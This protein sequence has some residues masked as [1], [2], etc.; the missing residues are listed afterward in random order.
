M[1]TTDRNWK[2]FC[3]A[4]FYWIGMIM[5]LACFAIVFAGN[6]DLIY[7]LQHSGF[8][9]S[10]TLAVIAM[11][12]FLAAEFCHT[13]LPSSEDEESSELAPE[14]GVIEA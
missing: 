11:L 5:A 10:W 12:S 6:T 13:D 8:P 7:R 2:A 9:L 1:R 4:G 14:W 3:Y